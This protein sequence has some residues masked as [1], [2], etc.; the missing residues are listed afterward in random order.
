MLMVIWIIIIGLI[1]LLGYQVYARIEGIEDT[2][3]SNEMDSSTPKY[4]SST[5][6][7]KTESTTIETNMLSLNTQIASLT[8]YRMF[9]RGV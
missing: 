9:H 3:S 1:L 6:A 4:E 7:L 8:T 2:P 5:V